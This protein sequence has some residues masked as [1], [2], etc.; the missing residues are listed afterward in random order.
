MIHGKLFPKNYFLSAAYVSVDFIHSV[1][2]PIGPY[3]I[4]F[5]FFFW[6]YW[7]FETI[8]SHKRAAPSFSVQLGPPPICSASFFMT[9]FQRIPGLLKG[10][11]PAGFSSVCARSS[12]LWFLQAWPAHR[13]LPL[14]IWPSI[15]PITIVMLSARYSFF[16]S[17]SQSCHP[18]P[19]RKFSATLFLLR[20]R[21]YFR[22]FFQA[23]PV[24]TKL[25]LLV[26]ILVLNYFSLC[27]VF[28]VHLP[29]E[30]GNFTVSGVPRC[31][32]KNAI[33]SV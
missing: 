17:I 20:P 14:L 9:S 6:I 15:C 2:T 26:Y 5:S 11:F 25:Q 30:N 32:L 22:P 29:Y 27:T 24:G 12:G 7:A 4:F 16:V 18:C 21:I 10:L 3:I 28:E 19:G 1:T 31:H 23:V 8:P 33:R 13:G